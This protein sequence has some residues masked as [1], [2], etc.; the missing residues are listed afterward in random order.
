M[1]FDKNRAYSAINADEVKVGSKV[2]VSNSLSHLRDLVEC[3]SKSIKTL[4]KVLDDN[5]LFRFS[6]NFKNPNPLGE[7]LLCYLVEEPKEEV[8]EETL[9]TYK[10]F[11][12]WV[13]Q[14][15]G[16]WCFTDDGS[17]K[18]CCTEFI[19]TDSDWDKL[20]PAGEYLVR[21]WDDSEWHEVTREYMEIK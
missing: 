5:Y 6:T 2:Y 7:W 20:V 8:K 10:E 17:L 12:Q 11:A 18:D 19:F 9:C 15:K 4:M 16:V 1:K 21:K 13:S 3:D 14:G